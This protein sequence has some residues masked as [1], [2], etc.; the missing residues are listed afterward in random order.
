MDKISVEGLTIDAI[1]GVHDWEK[2]TPQ[3]VVIDVDLYTDTRAAAQ[4]DDLTQTPGYGDL[5]R[6]VTDFVQTS[7][8]NLIETLAE[9]LSVLIL[10]NFS[11]ARI[12]IRISKPSA[13]KNATNVSVTIERSKT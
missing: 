7:R 6:I 11:V 10:E 4:K 5:A 13:I 2:T 8:F 12:R 1:I 9:Q 3:P